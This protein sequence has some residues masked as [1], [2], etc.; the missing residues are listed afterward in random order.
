MP[1]EVD[2]AAKARSD[3]AIAIGL[4]AMERF[5]MLALVSSSDCVR[6]RFLVELQSPLLTCALNHSSISHRT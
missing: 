1:N 4:L 3:F 2:V 5:G 6:N